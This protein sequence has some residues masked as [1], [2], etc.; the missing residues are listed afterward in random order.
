LTKLFDQKDLEW[1]LAQI[2]LFEQQ[3][4]ATLTGFEVARLDGVGQSDRYRLMR[5]KTGVD[6]GELAKLRRR[7]RMKLLKSGQLMADA[8][9]ANAVIR[10]CARCVEGEKRRYCEAHRSFGIVFKRL[11]WAG[12]DNMPTRLAQGRVWGDEE[13]KTA[14]ERSLNEW[15]QMY[16]RD[17]REGSWPWVSATW[18]KREYGD[19]GYRGW[20]EF[21]HEEGEMP[22]PEYVAEKA[23]LQGVA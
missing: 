15:E 3:T 6:L 12:E 22:Y 8:R 13:P 20:L 10:A 21:I 2:D 17:R 1:E 9:Y 18:S 5:S 11:K 19:L 14:E 7:S 4:S 16:Y 23:R